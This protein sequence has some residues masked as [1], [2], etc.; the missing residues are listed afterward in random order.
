MFE[1]LTPAPEDPILGLKEQFD[2]DPNPAKINL[3]AGV[4]KDEDGHTPILRTVKIAEARLLETETSKDYLNIHGSDEYAAAV[5]TLVFSPDHEVL[6]S[7]RIATIQTPG[8]T[9]GLRIAGELIKH[10]NHRARI[11]VSQPTWPNHPNIFRAAGL[12]VETYPYFDPATNTL[13]FEEMIATLEQIPEQDVV[14][15]HGCCHNPTGIDPTLDQWQR[16]ADV[17]ERRR[18]LPLVDF[19]YQGLANGIREDAAGIL[20]LCRPGCELIIVSSFAKNFGLYNERAGA[21]ILVAASQEIAGIALSHLKQYARA[22][23]SNPPSHGAL[24][25]TTILTDPLLRAEWEEEVRAMRERIHNTRRLFVQT[26]KAKGVTRDFS[27]IERQQGLFSFSGLTK[28]QTQ[29]LRERH[30]IYMVESGRINIAG[31][32]RHNIDTICQAIAQVL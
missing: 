19:A 5:Q 31:I 20:A 2:R 7:R 32:N 25:I 26:L 24:I 18:L 27:F 4:Y 28:E 14:L 16:I 1:I 30:S 12:E 22:C 15:L 9:G 23:Y 17:L 10:I 13:R 6:A 21:L 11:W 8:G 3:T 29:L